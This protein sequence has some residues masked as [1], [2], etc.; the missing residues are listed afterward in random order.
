MPQPLFLAYLN[1]LGEN[2]TEGRLSRAEFK[3]WVDLLEFEYFHEE[4]L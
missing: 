4:S 3:D 1:N 2:Y